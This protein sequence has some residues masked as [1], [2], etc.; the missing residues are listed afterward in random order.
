MRSS[1]SIRCSAKDGVEM[2]CVPFEDADALVPVCDTTVDCILFELDELVV[3]LSQPTSVLSS[4]VLFA[5]AR[6]GSSPRTHIS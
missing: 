1:L 5:L 3:E 4:E 2:R 6:V